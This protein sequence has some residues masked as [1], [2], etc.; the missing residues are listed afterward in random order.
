MKRPLMAEKL[1][2]LL[3]K[4]LDMGGQGSSMP[5]GQQTTEPV[6]DRAVRPGV[7][8]SQT[9]P[10]H[11]HPKMLVP[12]RPETGNWKLNVVKNQRSIPKQKVTFDMPFD[13]YSKQK[14]VTSDRMV[15]KG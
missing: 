7:Q 6:L 9:A 1:S 3:S 10:A 12:K 4:L 11:G 15:K 13:K 5:S 2:R 8:G 14:A